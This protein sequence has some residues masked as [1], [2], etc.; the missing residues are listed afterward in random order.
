VTVLS[1]RLFLDDARV[2]DPATGETAPTLRLAWGRVAEVGGRPRR[3]DRIVELGGAVV[4]PGL[5]NA[6]DH[7]QLNNFP[8]LKYREVYGNAQEWSQDLEARLDTD[9]VILAARAV[10][11]AGRLFL[12]GLKNLL[13][14]TTTVC[15]HDPFYR[16]LRRGNPVRVLRRYG[17]SHSLTRGGDVA[18]SWRHTPR[19]WP[20]IIH[21]AEGT[22]AS[23]AQELRTLDALGCLRPNTVVVHGVGLTD[24]DRADLA[25]RGGGLVWCPSSNLFLLGATARASELSQ[26]QRLAIGTDSR[27]TG[28]RD[29]LDELAVARAT[30]QL[31]GPALLRS[32]TVDAADLL[33]LTGVGRLAPGCRADV[34]I[35]PAGDP[36]EL[37]GRVRRDQ[38]RAVL[39]GGRVRVADPDFAQLVPGAV[40]A[41]L[42]GRPKLLDRRLARRV[43]A[44][45]V[46]E[47]G[48]EVGG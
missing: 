17:W 1:R 18:L 36:A 26:A 34:L 15:Q 27:L 7:L 43:A 20:W 25:A 14:G 4:L 11:L 37:V 32:V 12:G 22:D 8:R 35:L 9:R 29:L 33:R 24:R 44:C 31:D 28:S 30:G 16:P 10:P 13:S 38:I 47:P 41:T 19:R 40:A 2:F 23:A 6:H 21:L 5:V 39:L 46:S 42:D 48:L 3:G 45:P